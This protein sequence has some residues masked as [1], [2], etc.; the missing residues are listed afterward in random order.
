MRGRAARSGAGMAHI[1]PVLVQDAV[2]GNGPNQGWA[3]AHTP[4]AS[5]TK[6]RALLV[7]VN[8][9][10]AMGGQHDKRGIGRPNPGIGLKSDC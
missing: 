6:R 7:L 8:D 3:A 4:T 1:S 10:C 5:P 9:S 2:S